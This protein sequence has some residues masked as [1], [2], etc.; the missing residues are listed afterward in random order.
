MTRSRP[1]PSSPAPA[2]MG[3]SAIAPSTGGRRTSAGPVPRVDVAGS[4]MNRLDPEIIG[5]HLD[6]LLRTAQALCDSRE[7]AEDLVQETVARVISHLFPK[8]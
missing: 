8:E 7:S 3:T 5:A 6:R 2:A 1:T 4:G